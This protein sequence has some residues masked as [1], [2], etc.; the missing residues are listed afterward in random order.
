[1]LRRH[2]RSRHRG[3]SRLHVAECRNAA[4]QFFSARVPECRDKVKDR[5]K[6]RARDKTLLEPTV[7]RCDRANAVARIPRAQ[8]LRAAV[9]RLEQEVASVQAR[10]RR[11]LGVPWDDRHVPV[12]VTCRVV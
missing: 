7:R 2:R 5:D 3:R 11:P 10:R 8:G 6:A 9:R 4:S 1:M 12:S